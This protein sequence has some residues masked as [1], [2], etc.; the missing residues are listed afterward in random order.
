MLIRKRQL[1]AKVE[2]VEGTAET[3]AAAD[4]KLLVYSPKV[5]HDVE[6]FT[7]NPVRSSFSG[8]GKIAGRRP[9][10]LNFSMELRGSGVKTTD[11]EWVKL[12]KACGFESNVLKSIN[13]GAITNGPFQHGETITGGTSAGKGRVIINTATGATKV[14]YVIISGV[15]QTGETITGGTSGATATTSGAPVTEGQEYRPISAAV[16]SLTMGCYEDGVLKL[17]KGARGS[18][19]FNFKSGQ[20]VMLDFTFQ[21]VEAGI[22]DVALLSGISHETTKPPALLSAALVLDAYAARIGELNIDVNNALSSRDDINDPRGLLSFQITDRNISGSL[23]PE[24]VTVATYD[25]YSKFVGNTEIAIALSLGATTGN[26]FKFFAPKMQLTKID[27]ED[28][29]GM[30]LAKCSFDLNGT[31]NGDDEFSFIQL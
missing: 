3:L 12:L 6:F 16:S 10:G 30:Q 31:V 25:F 2:A 23:N 5:T 8:M 18:V 20:P 13:I 24:M 1:A 14:Y 4:A 9:A 22:T 28:R 27:D 17:I 29:D 11:A 7:R 26:M 15:L 21:G 19:K